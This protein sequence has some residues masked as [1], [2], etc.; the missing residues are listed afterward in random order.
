MKPVILLLSLLLSST[1]FAQ[2]V[3]A[4][5]TREVGE[6]F[7]ALEHSGCE[8]FRNGSWYDAQKASAHLHQK[9]DYLNNRGKITTTESFIELAATKSSMSG[10]AYMVRCGAGT[11][12]ES[13]VWFTKEL[14]GLRAKPAAPAKASKASS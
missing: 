3:P 13:R 8:F 14:K 2:S 10:E 12:V 9:Y 11:P 4:N 6:L 5:T 1:A 7:T